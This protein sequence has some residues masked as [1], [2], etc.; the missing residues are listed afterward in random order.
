M[1][2]FC[3]QWKGRQ[4]VNKK[5]A[6]TMMDGFEPAGFKAELAGA[7]LDGKVRTTYSFANGLRRG[8]AVWYE[9]DKRD[10]GYRHVPVTLTL[11]FA[12]R[13]LWACDPV[14]GVRQR[15]DVSITDGRTVVRNL[16]VGDAPL[17]VCEN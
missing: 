1:N 15:L 5:D 17:F 10:D 4:D 8:V 16:M 7:G 12:A 13:T 14:N 3:D 6:A 11:P 9:D 2:Y